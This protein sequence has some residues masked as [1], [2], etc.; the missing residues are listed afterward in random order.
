[1]FLQLKNEPD[2]HRCE[3]GPAA[4]PCVRRAS[5]ATRLFYL[6]TFIN[7][8]LILFPI[9]VILWSAKDHQCI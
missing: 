2:S 5:S 8:A 6:L 1:M 3:L 9:L 7:E 4:G